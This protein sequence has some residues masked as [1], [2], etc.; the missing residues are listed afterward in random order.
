[1]AVTV[2]LL[3]NPT[4][5]A[6]NVPGYMKDAEYR[7]RRNL[8]QAKDNVGAGIELGAGI[9][10]TDKGRV[11]PTV[12]SILALALVLSTF[13]IPAAFGLETGITAGF[14]AGISSGIRATA[15]AQAQKA[16]TS[17]CEACLSL[18]LNRN[19]PPF[20]VNGLKNK[21]FHGLNGNIN[22]LVGGRNFT[23]ADVDYAEVPFFTFNGPGLSNLLHDGGEW[24]G[25][26]GNTNTDDG[27]ANFGNDWAGEFYDL[28]K[29]GHYPKAVLRYIGAHSYIFVPPMFFPTLPRGISTTEEATP[30]PQ[31][32][33]NL[34]WPD[35]AGWGGD[36]YYYAPATG[37][38]TLDPRYVFGTDKNLARLK[39]KEIADEFDGVIYPKMR[40]YFGTE[41]DV[42]AD[43][44]IFIL[45]DDIRDGVGSF[46]GY[47]WAGNEYTRSQNPQSNEKELLYI[48]L[49]PTMVM[50]PKQG[51][52]TTAHEFVHMIHFNMG[53]G[54]IDGQ[55]IEEERWLE[56]GF[57]QYGQYIYNHSHTT[58]LDEF[59]K[60][61]DTILV[62]PRISV[63]LGPSP[64]ANYGA[65][66]LFVFYLA[67][68]FGGPNAANFL[69]NLVSDKAVGVTSIDNALRGFNTNMIDVFSDWAIANFLDKTKKLDMSPLND[70]KW[71]YSIDNDYDVTNDLG[72]NEHLP[73]KL[74][75]HVV[76]AP[77]GAVRS[78]SVNNWAADYIQ[79][80]GNN[81]NLN[82][83]FD[84]DDRAQFK[85]GVIKRGAQVD[86]SVEFIYLNERQLGNLIIKNYGSGNTYENLIL[87]PMVTALANYEL[88]NY[89]YSA[90][91][92]D[93]K[94]AIFPNPIYENNLHIVVRMTDKFS[95][96]P[97]LQMNFNGEQGYLTMNAVNDSTY[98]TN[99]PLK[100]SGEG[101]I[102]T[103]G[104]NSNGTILTNTLK[105]S[106]VY[107]PP[108]S[109]GLLKASFGTLNMAVGSLR[110]GGL[111]VLS[112]SSGQTSHAG[113]QRV[114]RTVDVSLPVAHLGT[115][116]TLDFPMLGTIP[117]GITKVGLFED[118]SSGPVWLG[119]ADLASGSVRGSIE[120]PG[121][122]FAA[123]D[124]QAPIIKADPLS[125][126]PGTVAIRVE[127]FGSGVD[128]ESISVMYGNDALH[129][130]WDE[131]TGRLSVDAG[132]LLDGRYPLLISL[133]DR[134]GNA[135]KARIDAQVSGSFGV[136]QVVTYPNPAVGFSVIR[137]A[138]TGAN[139]ANLSVVATIRDT[140]G[141]EV[142]DM[143]LFNKGGGLYETRWPL[144]DSGG[145]QVAN[146]IY[147]VTVE[148]SSPAGEIK[149][150][151]KI[152]VLR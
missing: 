29:N 122:I 70:G 21:A 17:G 81:G 141:S 114:S 82:L 33:W 55:Q 44:K 95:T 151:R 145:S 62:D 78:S 121:S 14:A 36:V 6:D 48:D 42:D 152:A 72:V 9:G 148:A 25:T 135:V 150:R 127:E 41:P 101:L 35:T 124:V 85:V 79:I 71:G 142:F 5:V 93:L 84:G 99:Y 67:E 7:R 16:R 88:M 132:G 146:G 134:Q 133:R 129:S 115:P 138:F 66:Y 54:V 119:K 46:R 56:E 112:E 89:V 57:T 76:L 111:V 74:S 8:V 39:L 58:N 1:M 107:Y 83:G 23:A 109:E 130:A 40:E 126:R 136:A 24:P 143:N 37:A 65:S 106:A 69:R 103:A 108:K 18:L 75:E 63:W 38:K 117:S 50:N 27:R 52:G 31:S 45:L 139:A 94:V 47:F 3:S 128:P 104:T 80:S 32:A 125:N 2:G 91:F 34:I 19:L 149:E 102:E 53:T 43:P 137:A 116:A 20:Q 77:Q 61:P 73:V 26:A 123:L 28:D 98:I 86:P 11:R 13:S 97:R 10:A 51:Y 22:T 110:S 120:R 12:F 59:I 90:T 49:F 68:H 4:P 30:A 15:L 118:T 113:L 140:S 64:F 105:F 87:V 147:Y 144:T 131:T 100:I 96:T 92:D 60:K